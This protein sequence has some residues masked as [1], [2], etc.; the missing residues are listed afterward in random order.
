MR[1]QPVRK[2]G[3][4]ELNLSAT[5]TRVRGK[6]EQSKTTNTQL[7]ILLPPDMFSTATVICSTAY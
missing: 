2:R 1:V 6:K 5:Q 7:Y 3:V 4:V